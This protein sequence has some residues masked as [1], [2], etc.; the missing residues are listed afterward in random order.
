LASGY[1]QDVLAGIGVVSGGFRDD[2]HVA[3]GIAAEVEH[4]VGTRN[5]RRGNGGN[6]TGGAHWDGQSI[7]LAAI[8]LWDEHHQAD[9]PYSALDGVAVP[10]GTLVIDD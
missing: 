1:W 8:W 7:H 5:R 10:N 3:A 4:R 6:A 9:E 2:A